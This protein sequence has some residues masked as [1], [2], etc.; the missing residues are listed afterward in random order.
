MGVNDGVAS[1][2]ARSCP[3][4]MGVLSSYTALR[5]CALCV[6]REV[7][8]DPAGGA[9]GGV[10]YRMGDGLAGRSGVR[11]VCVLSVKELSTPLR[12]QYDS[13]TYAEGFVSTVVHLC[14]SLSLYVCAQTQLLSAISMRSNC[15]A[16]AFLKCHRIAHSY[17]HSLPQTAA[18]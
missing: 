13:G 15:V 16:H 10:E 8:G 7:Q 3:V 18:T 14:T 1:L 4:L 17:Y 5:N 12:D 2:W 9:L 11:T 6:L